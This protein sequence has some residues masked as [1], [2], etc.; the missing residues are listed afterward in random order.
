[1]IFKKTF[2]LD[3]VL[4]FELISSEI[5]TGNSNFNKTDVEKVIK[6]FKKFYF[7]LLNNKIIERSQEITELFNDFKNLMFAK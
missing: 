2:A 5:C 6:F 4:L 1:M 7:Y 3:R